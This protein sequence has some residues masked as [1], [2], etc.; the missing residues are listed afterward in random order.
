M[1]YYCC[2]T[3][4]VSR[5]SINNTAAVDHDTH[6]LHL[7]HEIKDGRRSVRAVRDALLGQAVTPDL[8]LH[9]MQ[10]VHA[11]VAVGQLRV[12]DHRLLA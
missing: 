11:L 1:A 2:G 5:C 10:V 3:P 12:V 7:W 8:L 4:L 9:H 6:L